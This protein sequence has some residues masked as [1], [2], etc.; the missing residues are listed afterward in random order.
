[1]IGRRISGGGTVYHDKGNLNISFFFPKRMIVKC[2]NMKQMNEC[3]TNIIIE[4]LKNSGIKELS[5][6]GIYNIFYKGKKVSGGAGYFKSDWLLH[7][8]TLL[9]SSNLEHLNKSLLVR[10]DTS[11]QK[12]K[13]FPTTNL[14]KF[15][16]EKW[17][18]ILMKIIERHFNVT[19]LEDHISKNEMELAEKLRAEMYSKN[20][21]IRERKRVYLI[22]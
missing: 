7:H 19:F 2:R 14:P 6:E 13:Y 12:H 16:M 21:W 18:K 10:P 3:F 11:T 5:K 20:S 17:Q 15:D 9:I 4:S 1:M 22:K 8:V